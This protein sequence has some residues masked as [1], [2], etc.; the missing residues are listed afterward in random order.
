M[1]R[2]TMLTAL[3][4][5][6]LVTAVEGS[7]HNARLV[8]GSL[9]TLL[10]GNS[11]AKAK[12]GDLWTSDGD[13]IVTSTCERFV[14]PADITAALIARYPQNA[15]ITLDNNYESWPA[16]TEGGPL[17]FLTDAP[18]IKWVNWVYKVKIGN[19][20]RIELFTA[21]LKRVHL[22]QPFGPVDTEHADQYRFLTVRLFT[23]H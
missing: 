12:S 15:Q 3:L 6:V 17:N 14:G 10:N 19:T 20:T 13:L 1:K 5:F 16:E 8:P 11:I 4:G 22:N 18:D 2:T 21:I 9:S 7:G 23:L